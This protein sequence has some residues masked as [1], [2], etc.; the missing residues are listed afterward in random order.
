MKI[1]YVLFD[2]DGVIANTEESN[3][4]YLKKALKIH[5]I[6]LNDEDRKVLIGTS[7]RSRLRKILSRDGI[8]ITMEEFADTRKKVGNTYENSDIHPL[9]GLI[10]MILW[11]RK[12]GIKTAIATSTTTKLIIVALNRMGMSSMFDAV[13]CGDMCTES[14]PSPQIYQKAMEY[15]SAVPEECVVIEDS[16]PGIH[17]GKA[18][19]AYVIAYCGSGIK[20]D[21]HEADFSAVTYEECREKLKELI[22]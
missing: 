5:G 6:A 13:V 7:D 10:P 18:A 19:N 17:A 8:S 11:L 1:K 9:P 22:I 14:K 15:L 3:A 20:Q 16:A 2:F 4:E 21:I 12:N